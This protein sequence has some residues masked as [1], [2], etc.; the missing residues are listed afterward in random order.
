LWEVIEITA[1]KGNTYKVRW[2]GNDP[3]TMKPWP[4]SWVKKTDCTDDLVMEWKR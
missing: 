1:E 4:Q 2:K 3:K